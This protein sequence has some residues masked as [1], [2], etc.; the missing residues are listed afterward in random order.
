M[1]QTTELWVAIPDSSLSEKGT[2]REKSM[3]VSQIAR[4]CSIFR[5]TRIYIYHDNTAKITKADQDLLKIILKFLNTPPYLRRSV[6]PILDQLQYSGILHPIIAPHHK[7][8]QD[9]REIHQGDVRV[10]LILRKGDKIFADVGLRD[11][12]RFMGNAKVDTV[13]NLKF[14]ATYPHQYVVEATKGDIGNSYWGYDVSESIDLTTL[15]SNLHSTTLL[16]TSKNGVN[17][18]KIEDHFSKRLKSSQRLLVIFG[19]P[20]S[21]LAEIL[22]SEERN[23]RDFEFVVN[24]FPTQGTRTVRLEEAILGT[25]SIVNHILS[26]PG[27]Q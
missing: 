10:G 19:A 5:I 3:L 25:L 26:Y 17:F 9:L 4:A 16:L 21:G 23:I 18:R 6:Y 7:P 24:S 8:F 2:K 11:P 1:P 14:M 20:K 15:M 13:L 22:K 12:V 27:K